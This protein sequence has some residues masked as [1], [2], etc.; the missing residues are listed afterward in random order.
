LLA[1]LLVRGA[2]EALDAASAAG[3]AHGALSADALGVTSRGRV[4]VAGAGLLG[5]FGGD[6]GAADAGDAQTLATIFVRA[7]LGVDLD[8][9]E[10]T[11][12]PKDLT[13][14][15]RRLVHRTLRGKFPTSVAE[16]L[17][18]LGSAEGATLS[19][20]RTQLRTLE[21]IV[22]PKP[23]E[24]ELDELSAARGRG[25]GTLPAGATQE[26]IDEW[27]LEQLLEEE[28]AEQLPT[29]T[30]AI[31]DLLHRRFP[32]SGRITNYLEAAHA[33]ALRGPR[34]NGTLWTVL[35]LL[36]LVAVLAN[37]A[38]N[39]FRAPYVPTFDLKNPPPQTY[40]S[41][42]FGP[43]PTDVPPAP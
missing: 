27:E 34:V 32:R 20:I 19:A 38:I 10:D 17:A 28:E 40:P 12:L 33:R 11:A 5:A 41:F 36:V 1:R 9:A 7:V 6:V 35:G 31:L 8:D 21:R 23:E 4:I 39:I 26:E 14:S 37:V 2:S 3:L 18:D 22:P 25:V 42:T 29:I 15:E 43:S 24:P 30:E 16:L 13:R